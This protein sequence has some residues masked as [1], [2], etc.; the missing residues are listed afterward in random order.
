[1][2]FV[3]LKLRD[4]L[5]RIRIALLS[6][7]IRREMFAKFTLPHRGPPAVILT[8]C[9]SA[10]ESLV[11]HVVEFVSH[12]RGGV[13]ALRR[14]TERCRHCSPASLEWGSLIW[15]PNLKKNCAA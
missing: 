1:M 11:S 14:L 4:E 5:Y 8:F 3:G 7:M 12:H 15:K 13:R 10:G 9:Q 6:L 2:K